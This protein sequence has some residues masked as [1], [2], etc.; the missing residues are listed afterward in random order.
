MP[1]KSVG[2][3]SL[4]PPVIRKV[5]SRLEGAVLMPALENFEID[6]NAE[7]LSQESDRNDFPFGSL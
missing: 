6:S 5:L 4:V 7:S 3:V 2:N 1:N